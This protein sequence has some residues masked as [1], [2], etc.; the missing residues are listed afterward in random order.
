MKVGIVSIT[1]TEEFGLRIHM[2]AGDM[3]S[4]HVEAGEVS[5]DTHLIH[6]T[7]QTQ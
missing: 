3:A 1:V 4:I 6:K 5:T 2:Q 7:E